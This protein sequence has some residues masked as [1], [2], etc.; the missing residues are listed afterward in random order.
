MAP[1]ERPLHLQLEWLDR[2]NGRMWLLNGTILAT[3]AGVIVSLYLPQMWGLVG[4]DLPAP[5]TR[6]ILATGLCGLILV[7]MLYMTLKQRELGALR[8][9][10]FDARI[11]EEV[12]RSRL[13]EISSLFDVSTSVNMQFRIESI[14]DLITR[15]VLTCLEADQSSILL[16][17]P[18][19]QMLECRAVYGIDSEFVRDST[20]RLGDGIAGWVAQHGEP[21]VLNPEDIVRRFADS[22]KSGRNI[23][24]A[25]C[26]PLMSKGT[27]I[28][29]LNIN[30]I[31]RDRH[32]SP[33][34]ARILS[35]F[36]EHAAIAILK[37]EEFRA[38]DSRATLLEDANRRLAEVNR[39]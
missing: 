17:N 35:V 18:E 24:S 25:L 21:L 32:F 31:D 38:L 23:T 12:L 1:L 13:S 5:E 34:D 19:T 36:A 20:V 26:I 15:R 28:G 4:G 37:V 3:M 8:T 30:R 29:V 2:R 6:G 11:K 14:L 16:L 33:A 9:D 27:A 7:F 10:L 22:W 39:M